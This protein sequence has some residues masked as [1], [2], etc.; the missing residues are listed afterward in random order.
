[1]SKGNVFDTIA[2]NRVDS[3]VFDLSHDLKVSFNMGEMIPIYC[4][5]VIP[6]D[7]H[8]INPSAMLRFQPLIAPVMHKV[9]VRTRFFFV[10]LR[11][12]WED[13]GDW[14]MNNNDLEAPY[15]QISDASEGSIADYL[16]FPT[17]AND[18]TVS[19]MC[20]AAYSMIFDDWFRAQQFE[21]EKFVPLIAGQNADYQ[22]YKDLAPYRTT[23][24]QD[25]FTSALPSPQQGDAIMLPLTQNSQVDVQYKDAT[26]VA[27]Q[28]KVVPGGGGPIDGT[29][30]FEAVGSGN[31]LTDSVGGI[32]NM[33]PDSTLFV[34]V[35]ADA[36]SLNTLRRAE[37]LQKWLEVN[38]RAGSRYIEGM[39]AQFGV[40]SSD[41]RLQ[42]SEY[43]GGNKADMVISEVLTTA[44]TNTNDGSTEVPVG[45]MAGHGI[46]VGGGGT[47]SY[48]A[49]EHG[50]IMGIM[51]VTPRTA[52]QQGIAKKYTRLDRYDYA[53][54]LLAN[55]GEQEILNRELYVDHP[56]PLGVFGYTPRYSEYK[57]AN[58]RVSGSFRSDLAFWHW[59]RI[60][61]SSPELNSTFLR[62]APDYRPF[63]VID[64]EVDHVLAHVYFSVHVNRKLPYYGIPTI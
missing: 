52:Y 36:V 42:R 8:H 45:N 61:D 19:P 40:K 64:P 6:G 46:S 11:L 3:S 56:T 14:L 30:T 26:T 10:P 31:V 35:Q 43:I 59:G 32:V 7:V 25:Y 17:Q 16:G 58:N 29:P 5:D 15:V 21:T 41:A 49:E 57:F 63:A 22:D 12:L 2:R 48:R 39:L 27:Q 4:E 1:M 38:E 62:C 24:E 33:D 53:F 37:A 20:F 44:Q 51:T 28:W 23:W 18:Y 50:F 13:F 34:D 60:F 9:E 55:L 54:P 47:F